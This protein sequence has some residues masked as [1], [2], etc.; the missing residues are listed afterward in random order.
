MTYTAPC[1]LLAAVSRLSV[2]S[3]NQSKALS[4]IETLTGSLTW[5]DLGVNQ[6]ACELH[7]LSS[8]AI[9][10]QQKA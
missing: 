5:R 1:I 6:F 4:F 7:A 2:K 8:A 10:N 3:I 9:S